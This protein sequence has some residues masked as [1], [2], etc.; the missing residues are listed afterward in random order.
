MSNEQLQTI[1]NNVNTT[2]QIQKKNVGIDISGSVGQNVDYWDAVKTWHVANRGNLGKIYVWDHLVEE[3]TEDQ[4]IQYYTEMKGRGSTIPVNLA[5]KIITD[6]ILNNFTLFTDGDVRSFDVEATDFVLKD[7]IIAKVECYIVGFRSVNLSVTC[8]FCRNNESTV[9]YRTES[10]PFRIQANTR[11]NNELLAK[12]NTITLDTFF[13]KDY[14]QLKACLLARNMGRIG[15]ETT[16]NNLLDLKKKLIREHKAKTTR[17]FGLEIKSWLVLN[18]NVNALDIAS[19]LTDDYYRN[20]IGMKIDKKINKLCS[21]CEDLRGLYT[22]DSIKSNR[23]NRAKIVTHATDTEIA[24]NDVPKVIIKP[25]ECPIIM[26]LDVPQ[27]LVDD[28]DGPILANL[29]PQIVNN[30]INCPLSILNYPDVVTK[31]KSAISLSTGIKLNE[32]VEINPY[33]KRHLLGTI[34]LGNCQQHV[35]CG[36]YTIS[37]LFS[38]GRHLGNLNLYWAVIWQLINTNAIKY[39]EPIKEHATAHLIYRF[40]N[41]VTNASLSGLPQFVVNT[42][43][44]GVAVWY[45]VHSCLLNQPTDSDTARMHIHNM[46]IMIDILKE[47]DYPVSE[48]VPDQLNKIK[49]LLSMLSIVKKYPKR[50]YNRIICLY[51]NAVRLDSAKLSK[52]VMENETVVD[53]IPIDGPASSQQ[54]ETILATFPPIYTTIDIGDLIKIASLVDPNKAASD[55]PFNTKSLSAIPNAIAKI[56]WSLYGLKPYDKDDVVHISHKTFRPFYMVNYKKSNVSWICKITDIYGGISDVFSGY[57][58]F[59]DYFEKYEEFPN[60]ESFLFYSYNRRCN[61]SQNKSS[62]ITLPYL[63]SLWA[64][65][66]ITSYQPIFKLIKDKCLSIV[67]IKTILENSR[68]V[69]HRIYIEQQ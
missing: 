15:D 25:Y 39:L 4:L 38:S 11:E 7:H 1:N 34:P 54:I 43:P 53:W 3:I 27:I 48:Q 9:H 55:I 40:T 62:V 16:K 61:S 37:K 51:Q 49:I 47:L 6:K 12:L 23:I 33:T 60:T 5:R 20:N 18:D 69:D 66:I 8:S 29:D 65:D 50:F 22:I 2:E 64:V 26:S 68:K 58:L 13:E 56:N 36:N 30:I 35:D 17:D 45:C 57:R 42:V 32:F 44:T 21:L 19:Q 28:I 24:E 31:L 46:N 10:T 52:K 59:I 14:G 63:S 41:S 67:Q